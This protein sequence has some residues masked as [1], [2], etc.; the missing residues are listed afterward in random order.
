MVRNNI[1]SVP[2]AIGKIRT[3]EVDP[4]ISIALMRLYESV[5]ATHMPTAIL[6][7]CRGF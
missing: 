1:L 6:S 7:Y 4:L 3:T 2:V 5:F